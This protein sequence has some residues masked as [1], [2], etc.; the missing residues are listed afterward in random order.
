MAFFNFLFGT[1]E[2]TSDNDNILS[3]T[4]FLVALVNMNMQQLNV[5]TPREYEHINGAI[6]IN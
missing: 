3:S 2:L 5:R 4:S 6:N 1:S